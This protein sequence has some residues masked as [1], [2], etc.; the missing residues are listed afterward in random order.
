MI[1]VVPKNVLTNV[2]KRAENAIGIA[3]Q[4]RLDMLR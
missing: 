3:H 4:V 1:R 2:N